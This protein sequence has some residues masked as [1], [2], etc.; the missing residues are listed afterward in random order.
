MT[1]KD[2]INAIH[3]KDSEAIDATFN[4]AM[5]ERITTKLDA[6]KQSVAQGMFKTETAAA[7]EAP[8]A[9]VTPEPTP[10]E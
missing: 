9:E 7:V 10:A 1:T 2:L 8:A 5:A 6:M 3:S 4:A